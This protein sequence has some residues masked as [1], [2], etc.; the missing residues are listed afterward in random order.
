MATLNISN[1]CNNITT[2]SPCSILNVEK[3]TL[4]KLV[5]ALQ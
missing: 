1:M 3:H 5:A 4:D 2:N